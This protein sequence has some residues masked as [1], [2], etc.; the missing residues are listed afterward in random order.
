[1]GSTARQAARKRARERQRRIEK[2]LAKHE[3]STEACTARAKV[4]HECLTCEKLRE[5]GKLK[6]EPFVVYACARHGEEALTAV[7]K[8]ALAS[9]PANILR[10]TVAALKGEKV[11]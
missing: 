9:H 2:E 5:A 10:A 11:F 8:H 1:M 3:C 4:K 7:K 6:G